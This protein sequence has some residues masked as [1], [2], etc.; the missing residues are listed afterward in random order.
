MEGWECLVMRKGSQLS[1]GVEQQP[2]NA[3]YKLGR[4]AKTVGMVKIY[5]FL[6]VTCSIHMDRASYEG[7][8]KIYV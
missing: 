1:V 8:V 6:N 4:F 5:T 2:V 3:P 7:M